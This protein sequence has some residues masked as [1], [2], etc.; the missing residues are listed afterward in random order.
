MDMTNSGDSSTSA[1]PCG[2][3]PLVAAITGFLAHQHVEAGSELRASLE[4]VI[5][6][7][8][9]EAIEGLA[10]RLAH[11]G[12]DWTYYPRDPL[13][14]RIHY[15]LAEPVLKQAPQ[16]G[17]VERLRRIAGKP[18]VMFA[19]HLSYADANVVEVVL[20]MAGEAVLSERLT[21]VAGPKVY[22]NVRRR[23]SSLCFGTVKVPQSTARSSEEAVMEPREVAR[24]ARRAIDAAHTRLRLGDALLIFPEGSRSRTG[25]M[26]PLLPGTV[27]YLDDSAETWVMP[28]GIAGSDQLFPLAEDSLNATRLSVRFGEPI[29]V[30]RLRE[31]ARRDRRLM[32]DAIGFAIA[33]LI[34]RRYRGAYGDDAPQDAARQLAVQLFETA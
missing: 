9:R 17:G 34:P 3:G 13:A 33:D 6:D 29:P 7:A 23:F 1:Q 20:Q 32:I 11:A 12:A 18:V 24:A 30:S 5:D 21:V 4:R 14:R 15:L 10:N 19:N 8:G 27:R 31:R 28:V 16:I 25:D 2:R 26:Q 22:S